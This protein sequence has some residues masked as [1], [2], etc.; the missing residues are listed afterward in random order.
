VRLTVDGKSFTQPIEILKDPA[1][2]GTDADLE[3][4][5]KL[6]LHIRD[7]ISATA[8]IVNQIEWMRKQL[9]D[10]QKMLRGQRDKAD[11][12]KSAQD[13]D[14]K[15]LSVETKLLERTGLN[16]DD[17]Y[18]VEAYKV[19]MNL[20]WLNGEVGMGAGDVS[21]GADWGPTETSIAVLQAIEKDL[22]AA[23]TEYRGLM[24]KEVPAFNRSMAE[25]GITPL[26]AGGA[27]P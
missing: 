19:Y 21:G 20:I 12:L 26:A 7:D 8:D 10:V 1:T 9:E 14:Q 6:Q 22:D 25:K 16:S 27:R 17:K 4:G 15:L 23:R 3:A 18:F 11:V 2:E 13:M 24:D 5:L